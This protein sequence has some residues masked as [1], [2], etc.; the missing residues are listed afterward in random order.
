MKNIL[1]LR[2][3]VETA[4]QGSLSACARKMDLSPAVVSAS[5]KR[6]EAELNTLL[7]VRSTR[8]LRLTQKG[9]SFL[10]QCRNALEILDQAAISLQTQ[11]PELTG[12]IQLSAPSDL[13]RNF[14]VPW[15]DEFLAEHNKVNLRLEL[16]DSPS[17]LF[18]QPVDLAIRYGVPKDSSLI[19][20]SLCKNNQPVLVA[21]PEYL[22]KFGTPTEPNDLLQHNCLCHGL[23]NV[24]HSRWSFF[25]DGQNQL[26]EVTGDRQCKDGDVTRRWAVAGRG[27]A[28]KSK[29][30][31]AEDCLA[32][33]LK[34]IK[35]GG[36]QGE[37]LPLNLVCAERRL[38]S[39]TVRALE[40]FL[41]D[42][43]KTLLADERLI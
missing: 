29:L 7:F 2:I 43:M 41:R 34:I 3:F 30:D 17:D 22:K 38:L 35:L 6:L 27:I 36:W 31:V 19:A 11:T 15:F 24:L 20:K 25:K 40:T 18:S 12:T 39:P 23:N 37:A 21:S 8:K 13:G 26:V 10:T 33:R 1:D 16:S 4:H 5:V 42:K 28:Y 32:G 14:L 9:E